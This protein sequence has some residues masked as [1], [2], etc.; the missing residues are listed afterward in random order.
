MNDLKKVE[1]EG[2]LSCHFF[3]TLRIVLKRKKKEEEPQKWHRE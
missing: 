1:K 3:V 2:L